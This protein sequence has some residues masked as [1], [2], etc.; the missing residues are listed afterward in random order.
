MSQ[1]TESAPPIANDA[2][3]VEAASAP[4]IPQPI[5]GQSIAPLATEPTESSQPISKSQQKK[6]KKKLAWEASRPD[7][8]LRRKEKL[9]QRR[10]RKR[11]ARETALANGDA[12]PTPKPHIP[13]VPAVQLPITFII[14]C[15]FDDLMR[16]NE[17]VSLGLQITRSYS[18]NKHARFAAH[19]VVAS[20]G[21]RLKDRFENT[22]NRQHESWTA[23]QFHT[24]DFVA[25]AQQARESMSGETSGRLAGP[26]FEKYSTD[27]QTIAAARADAETIYLT[28][29]SDT[30]LT[31]LKP[32][33]TYIIGG[34]VDK[35]REKGICHKRASERNIKTA[36]LPIGEYLDM[37]SRKVLTTNHVV[38]IMLQWLELGDW[39]K[40]FMNVI[41]KRKEPKLRNEKKNTDRAE[42]QDDGVVV[43]DNGVVVGDEHREGMDRVL[44]SDMSDDED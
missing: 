22:L 36:R 1:A 18:D 6:L 42:V 31:E 29:D 27:E 39:G 20:F 8:R 15:N 10:E 35:N 44:L 33:S 21:A 11:E 37:A 23:M 2:P 24:D 25:V 5:L 38:A 13:P 40:A 12:L 34:L 14:D 30:T 4:S 26:A 16:E 32:F 41:P 7:R 19:C 28:S 3:I 9:V 17:L 43:D